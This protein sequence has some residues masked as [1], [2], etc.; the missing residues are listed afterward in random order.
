MTGI[1]I[2]EILI[3]STFVLWIGWDIYAYIRYGNKATESVRSYKAAYYAP[4]V[5]VLVGI[6]VGHLFFP[7]SEV[8]QEIAAQ[9]KVQCQHQ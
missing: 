2:T 7:Q 4:G 5:G 8:V 9:Q 3:L 6:L 1:H